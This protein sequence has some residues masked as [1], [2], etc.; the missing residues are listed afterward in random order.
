MQMNP[1]PN[2]GYTPQTPYS[3]YTYN[4]NFMQPQRMQQP[5]LQYQQINNQQQQFQ[6][7][8][9]KIVPAMENINPNDVPMDGSVAFFPKQDLSE[10]YVKSWNADGTIR[11]ITFKPI[12]EHKATEL[13]TKGEP[14]KLGLSDE[15]TEAFMQRFDELSK[16]IEKLEK[17]I[18]KPNNSI[19]KRK[20]DAE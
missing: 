16:H 1:Y 12:L 17:T 6:S 9:G 5:E 7:V 2:L 10:I 14:L 13:S 20:G 11:T 19:G 8:N 15:V 3:P 4:M 18:T